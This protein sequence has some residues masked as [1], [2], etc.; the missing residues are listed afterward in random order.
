MF[1]H[2]HK[3]NLHVVLAPMLLLSVLMAC[4]FIPCEFGLTLLFPNCSLLRAARIECISAKVSVGPG[5]LPSSSLQGVT[6][7][8]TPLAECLLVQVDYHHLRCRVSLNPAPHIVLLCDYP[9]WAQ[10]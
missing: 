10:P 4:T 1:D 8:C 2:H 6:E 7:F 5:V 9:V 3:W